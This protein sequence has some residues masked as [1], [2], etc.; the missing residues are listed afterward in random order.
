[1]NPA[2]PS[3][4]LAPLAKGFG[5]SYQVLPILQEEQDDVFKSELTPWAISVYGNID[6]LNIKAGTD[7]QRLEINQIVPGSGSAQNGYQ[8]ITLYKT[9][10]DADQNLKRV[11][12]T[13]QKWQ[14][15]LNPQHFIA[16]QK[17]ESSNRQIFNDQFSGLVLV[18]GSI[19]QIVSDGPA[20]S[21]PLSIFSTNDIGVAGSLL[22]NPSSSKACFGLVTAEGQIVF[23]PLQSPP[24]ADWVSD[25][26]K[27]LDVQAALVAGSLM[28]PEKVS[29]FIKGSVAVLKSAFPNSL[30]TEYE[31]TFYSLN[32]APPFFPT[33]N[34]DS[35]ALIITRPPG[36]EY[37]D[38]VTNP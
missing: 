8:S 36:K 4:Y 29:V 13:V 12:I 14:T 30:K 15:T 10:I 9:L 26:T 20:Y 27:A 11:E 19:N 1:M 38:M 16:K 5:R 23:H 22:R 35:L 2:Q 32:Q 17:L 6:H 37:W 31:P 3:V 25:N 24:I 28:L 18:N 34:P 33:L 7:S 21:R